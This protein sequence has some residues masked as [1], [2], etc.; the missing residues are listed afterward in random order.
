MGHIFFS[1]FV[2]FFVVLVMTA[3]AN[4]VP[5]Y[6]EKNLYSIVATILLLVNFAT[7]FIVLFF[8]MCYRKSLRGIWEDL[9]DFCKL[10]ESFGIEIE[11][12][13]FR[14]TSTSIILILY[15]ISTGYFIFDIFGD[16]TVP[17]NIKKFISFVR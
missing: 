6:L 1:I 8:G 13:K 4:H 7:Y 17:I 5:E 10:F 15:G 9:N 14:W 12:K 16:D 2:I 11:Y 3:C